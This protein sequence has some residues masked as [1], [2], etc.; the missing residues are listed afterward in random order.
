MKVYTWN[1]TECKILIEYL[2]QTCE[3]RK[4]GWFDKE[5]LAWFELDNV[6]AAIQNFDGAARLLTRLY[7][8]PEYRVKGLTSGPPVFNLLRKQLE[9]SCY[10]FSNAFV[11]FDHNKRGVAV[12]HVKT[13]FKYGIKAELLKDMYKTCNDNHDKCK[14]HIVL[15]R[16]SNAEFPLCKSI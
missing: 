7:I 1:S 15:Y 2:K 10:R 14:Q 11:S 3:D 8:E 16:F 9:W 4:P 5:V 6:Y 13:A 12:R